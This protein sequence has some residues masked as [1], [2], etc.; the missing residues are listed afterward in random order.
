MIYSFVYHV[1]LYMNNWKLLK[2]TITVII[3]VVIIMIGIFLVNIIPE[4][5]NDN[6]DNQNNA[7][8]NI[9]A[10][11]TTAFLKSGDTSGVQE[12][13]EKANLNN[14]NIDESNKVNC[15]NVTPLIIKENS[16]FEIFKFSNTGEAYLL[17]EEQVYKLGN[18]RNG[19]GVISFA[20]A[21]FDQNE[22]QELYFSYTWDTGVYRTNIAYFD[23]D[24]KKIKGFDNIYYENEEVILV[25]KNGELCAV[26][27]EYINNIDKTNFKLNSGKVLARI[28]LENDEIILK[29]VK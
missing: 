12:F 11:A 2:V 10:N 4:F 17:F 27:A 1:I 21:D 19:D 3:L 23:S 13:F 5:L 14:V 26:H 25:E 16:E 22:K 24:E 7:D 18:S 8:N 28:T 15:Y 20:L 6:E 9:I 29:E